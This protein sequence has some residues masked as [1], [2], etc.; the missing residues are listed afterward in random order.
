MSNIA[1]FSDAAA[2]VEILDRK[3]LLTDEEI[4]RFIVNG[5]I[6]RQTDLPLDFHEDVCRRIDE[7]FDEAGGNPQNEILEMV[8]DLHRVYDEP[9]VKGALVSLLGGDFSM[10]A[11]RHCHYTN[12]GEKGGHWHQDSI[13]RRHHQILTVLGIYYPQDV[14]EEMGP[15]IILP[16]TQYHNTPSTQMASYLNFRSQVPLNVAAG[17]VAIAHYDIWH[18]W[19]DNRYKARRKPR[20]LG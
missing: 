14:T 7:S 3:Y 4:E 18:S 6:F 13:N 10:S 20:Q 12:P 11:H 15:T 2:G 19:M 8:P 17:T 9:N 1:E 5:Y 16:G